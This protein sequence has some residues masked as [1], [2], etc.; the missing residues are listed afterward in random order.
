MDNSDMVGMIK[1]VVLCLILFA[2]QRMLIYIQIYGDRLAWQVRFLHLCRPYT[3]DL[4]MSEALIQLSFQLVGCLS[5]DMLNLILT[6]T[7]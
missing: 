2:D 4:V 3:T 5:L 7:A 1:S 6:A